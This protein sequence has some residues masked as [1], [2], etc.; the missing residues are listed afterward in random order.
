LPIYLKT[1]QEEVSFTAKEEMDFKMAS[2]LLVL[3]SFVKFISDMHEE[4][5]L[6][7][8]S[9]Y[10]TVFVKKRAWI[11]RGKLPDSQTCEN[12]K[13]K[14]QTLCNSTRES[15]SLKNIAIN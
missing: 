14:R 2:R 15:K 12:L 8:F 6:F 3:A 5:A 13:R 7:F 10:A 9:G 4:F 1:N 11:P